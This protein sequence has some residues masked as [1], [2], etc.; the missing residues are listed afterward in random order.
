[1][2]KTAILRG[3][4]D[5]TL[6]HHGQIIPNPLEIQIQINEKTGERL[7]RL[8]S[9]NKTFIPSFRWQRVYDQVIPTGLEIQMDTQTGVKKARLKQPKELLADDIITAGTIQSA[10]YDVSSYSC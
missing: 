5:W 10:L 6:I 8:S 4:L 3:I 2:S 1:M 9:H 7:G